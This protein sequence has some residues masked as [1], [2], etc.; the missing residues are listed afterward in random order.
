VR[1]EKEAQD[2][3]LLF[4]TH[5]GAVA[6][7]ALRRTPSSY[8]AADAVAQT[9]EI[10]WRRRN[11]LPESSLILPWLFATTR[12]VLAN[13][14]RRERGRSD[15]VRRLTLDFE[16]ATAVR[17]APVDEEALVVLQVFSKLPPDDQE[18]LGLFGWER[19]SGAEIA[20]SMDLTLNA[21][22]VRL[23]RARA[24]FIDALRGAGIAIDVP[25]QVAEK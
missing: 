12:R 25:E 5:Y 18:V 9:F 6:A 21:T 13:Q 11:E 4:R 17:E 24:R 22:R 10:A 2:F 3:G 1:G 14:R 20:A 8:D 7:Y 19:L 23:H 16:R 15:V